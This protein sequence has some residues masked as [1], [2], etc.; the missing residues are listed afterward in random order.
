MNFLDGHSPPDWIIDSKLWAVTERI[1][2]LLSAINYSFKVSKL[3]ITETSN[4]TPHSHDLLDSVAN[5]CLDVHVEDAALNFE[6]KFLILETPCKFVLQIGIFLPIRS[7]SSLPVNGCK[8][9]LSSLE[10]YVRWL[11]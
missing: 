6:W 10:G 3:E 4:L 1:L 8:I 5:F 2:K 7:L 9:Q 11:L